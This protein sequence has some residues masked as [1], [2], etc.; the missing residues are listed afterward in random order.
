MTCPLV[1]CADCK[2]D[3]KIVTKTCDKCRGKGGVPKISTPLIQASFEP[4]INNDSNIIQSTNLIQTSLEPMQIHQGYNSLQSNGQINYGNQQFNQ[5]ISSS[6]VYTN[7]QFDQYN[8]SNQQFNQQGINSNQ[9]FIQQGQ[10]VRAQHFCQQGI[11][12]NQQYN[13]QG[14][15]VQGQ[16]IN[17]YQQST[18][19]NIM[20]PNQNQNQINNNYQNK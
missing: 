13:Q 3:G 11:D 5:E 20:N 8:N 9:Q 15:F 17:T 19:G 2:G 10:F 14:Q 1:I 4:F 16:G 12:S 6:E 18:Q 7:Q